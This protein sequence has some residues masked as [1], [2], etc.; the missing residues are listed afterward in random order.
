M[1]SKRIALQHFIFDLFKRSH[2]HNVLHLHKTF[3]KLGED[4]ARIFNAHPQAHL[5]PEPSF[6]QFVCVGIQKFIRCTR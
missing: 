3:T 1:E 5:R 4:E 2:P 6:V